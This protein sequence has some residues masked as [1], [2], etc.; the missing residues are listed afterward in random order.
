MA[1]QNLSSIILRTVEDYQNSIDRTSDFV[2]GRV[3]K[4]GGEAGCRAVRI[5]YRRQ[6]LHIQHQA[7]NCAVLRVLHTT[8]V[9]VQLLKSMGRGE[10]MDQRIVE[11][12]IFCW[13][14]LHLSQNLSKN[15]VGFLDRSG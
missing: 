6:H 9:C 8:S 3:H 4:L 5:S 7:V 13:P 11:G 2:G 1:I 15:E 14:F 12:H 10:I